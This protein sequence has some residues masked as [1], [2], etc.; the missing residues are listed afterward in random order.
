MTPPS[1]MPTLVPMST[2]VIDAASASTATA[3]TTMAAPADQ[4]GGLGPA[5]RADIPGAAGGQDPAMSCAT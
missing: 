3:M 5:P 4:E 1:L 2:A